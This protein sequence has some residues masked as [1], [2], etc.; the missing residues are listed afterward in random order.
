MELLE[1]M[2]SGLAMASFLAAAAIWLPVLA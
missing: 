2:I 1:D